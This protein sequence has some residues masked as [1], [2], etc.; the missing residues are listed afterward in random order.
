M[1]SIRKRRNVYALL[2]SASFCLAVC[3]AIFM[4]ETVFVFGAVSLIS[5]LLFLRESRRF[6]DA[7]LIWENRIIAVPSA[8]ISMPGREMKKD[9]EETV[10][11]TFGILIGKD[12]YR[13]GFDGV[14]GARLHT[15][16]IDREWMHL[17]F[18]DATQ[19][20]Q[21]DLLHGMSQKQEVF[22]SVQKLLYE[23]GVQASIT[24][25]Q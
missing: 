13:W 17:T 4:L 20:M 16:E 5:F 7:M 24:G 10:V 18:G 6:Y 15:A 3:L 9:A 14:H 23:T 8:L 1:E 22:D 2:F 11:S 25:W 21:V 12:I 19:T